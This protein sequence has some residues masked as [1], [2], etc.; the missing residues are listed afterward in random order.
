[1]KD[2]VD[3]SK[4]KVLGVGSLGWPGP[5]RLVLCEILHAVTERGQ[6]KDR[7]DTKCLALKTEEGAPS[8]GMQKPLG[9]AESNV[10]VQ[11]P[12]EH[13]EALPGFSSTQLP[14][15]N[16]TVCHCAYHSYKRQLLE[17]ATQTAAFILTPL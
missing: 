3:G 7:R 2:S 14:P 17:P 5:I 4:A 9:K 8:Q 15:N 12:C 6:H 11:R 16:C 1:M 13:R 10:V